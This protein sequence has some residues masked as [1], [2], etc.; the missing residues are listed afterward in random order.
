[1]GS[2]AAVWHLTPLDEYKVLA[3]SAL[4]PA[5]AEYYLASNAHEIIYQGMEGSDRPLRDADVLFFG[6]S[7]PLV[8]FTRSSLGDFFERHGLSY[9]NL[10][11]SGGTDVFAR[12]LVEKF[13]LAP[14]LAIIDANEFFTGENTPMAQRV[15]D[16]SR[17][18]A[19]KRVYERRTAYRVRHSLHRALPHLSGRDLP[20]IPSW[21]IFRS[22]RDGTWEF[23]AYK[24]MQAEPV[25]SPPRYP[26]D[27]PEEHFRAAER[28]TRLLQDRGATVVLTFVP[29]ARNDRWRA[30]EIS[31]RLGLPLISPELPD[32]MTYDGSHLDKPGVARFTG[33]FL[34]EL[35]DRILPLAG[36]PSAALP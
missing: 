25:Y 27:I 14:R 32:L 13:D 34:L 31:E 23:A 15:M 35:E 30:V 19:L 22:M 11:F 7:R 26:R 3:V 1:M 8:A 10:S 24:R 5:G 16:G 9:Y 21:M 12:A 28:F 17:F 36:R 18:D 4:R 20:W 6:S 2:I 33:A 29:S